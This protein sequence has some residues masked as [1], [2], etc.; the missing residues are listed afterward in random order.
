MR[1]RLLTRRLLPALLAACVVAALGCAAAGLAIARALPD[2]G[3]DCPGPLV[4]VDA[5]PGDFVVRQSARVQGDALDWRLTLVT[6]KR[7]D[8]LV[9]VGLETLGGTAFVVTQHGTD[10]DVQRPRGR[11]PLPPENLLHDVYRAR[12]VPGDAGEAGVAVERTSDG[13]VTIRHPDCG[14]TTTLVTLEESALPARSEG[15]P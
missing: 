11:L 9:L 12:F 3:P 7:G 10:V 2:A 8:T 14:Y 6:Q 13:G 1:R 4:P 5:L 15:P